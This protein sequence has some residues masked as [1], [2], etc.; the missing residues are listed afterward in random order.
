MPDWRDVVRRISRRVY[1]LGLRT[2]HAQG[3]KILE[4]RCRRVASGR[5]P[6]GRIRLRERN[7]A[8]TCQ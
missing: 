3:H 6:P 4:K 1:L 2:A 8:A 5:L 7:E